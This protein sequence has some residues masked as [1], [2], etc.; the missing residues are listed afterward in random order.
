MVAPKIG[1]MTN[2]PLKEYLMDIFTVTAN[3]AGIPAISIPFGMSEK[4]N[5]PIG[6]QFMAGS[7]QDYKLFD[8]AKKLSK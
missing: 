8:I 3:T 2:D 1:E 6:M 7:E 4:E 5:M